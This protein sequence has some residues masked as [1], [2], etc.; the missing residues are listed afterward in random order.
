MCETK[1]IEKSQNYGAAKLAGIFF[2]YFFVLNGVV[3]LIELLFFGAKLAPSA[4]DKIFDREILFAA[5]AV[6]FLALFERVVFSPNKNAP[7]KIDL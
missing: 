2:F 5:A 6:A 7:D 4:L 3:F 1:T